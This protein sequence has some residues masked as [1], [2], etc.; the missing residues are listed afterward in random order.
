MY[1][2]KYLRILS[3]PKIRNLAHNEI[4]PADDARLVTA[5]ASLSPPALTVPAGM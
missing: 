2:H 1:Y 4:L 3:Q 5:T